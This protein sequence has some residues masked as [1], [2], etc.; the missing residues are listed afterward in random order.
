MG[1]L[2]SAANTTALYTVIHR[3]KSTLAKKWIWPSKSYHATLTLAAKHGD[4]T[5]LANN[6]TWQKVAFSHPDTGVLR[7]FH[8]ARRKIK[9]GRLPREKNIFGRISRVWPG[10]HAMLTLAAKHGDLTPLASG[11]TWSIVAFSRPD[12]GLLR[13]FPPIMEKS[14]IWPPTT[15]NDFFGR[16]ITPCCHV[17]PRPITPC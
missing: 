9:F 11:K 5:P 13:I 8:P 14:K 15:E 17:W 4:L 12:T 3:P 7:I 1:S 2:T 6:K 10:Y 16:D